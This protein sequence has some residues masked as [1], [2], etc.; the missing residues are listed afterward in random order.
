VTIGGVNAPVQFAGLAP[1]FTGLYQVNVAVPSGITPG[2]N[3]PLV[4]TVAGQQ[5][6]AVTIAVK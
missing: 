5:S 4:L 6:S 2:D 3:V 1:T